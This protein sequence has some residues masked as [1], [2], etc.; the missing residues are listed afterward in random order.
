MPILKTIA[1]GDKRQLTHLKS[2]E[3]LEGEEAVEVRSEW[4]ADAEED[5]NEDKGEPK[6]AVMFPDEN[7]LGRG[8]GW[9]GRD[10]SRIGA[11]S[12]VHPKKNRPLSA[13]TPVA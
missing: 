6:E 13:L 1:T 5:A 8:R 7:C 3:K 11:S 10:M 12:A 9:S 4:D 2:E